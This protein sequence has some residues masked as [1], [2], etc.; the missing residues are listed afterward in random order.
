MSL[1]DLP[2]PDGVAQ[3]E[4]LRV[5]VGSELF[6]TG[7]KGEGD[8]DLMGVYIAPPS[9]VFGL[10]PTRDFKYRTQPEGVPSGPGDIDYTCFEFRKFMSL[11]AVGN[12][13]VLPIFFAS[14]NRCEVLTSL[15]EWMQ[16]SIPML[17]CQRAGYRYLGYSRGQRE[18]LERTLRGKARRQE[19]HDEYGYDTK[20]AMHTLMILHQG[21]ELMQDHTL[22]LPIKKPIRNTLLDVRYG[23]ITLVD[24]LR[25]MNSL[26]ADLINAIKVTTMRTNPDRNW[27]NDFLRE[28][29]ETFYEG[30]P[31]GWEE[32]A[33]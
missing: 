1:T 18:K 33:K 10:E 9:S 20:Y 15:G 12:P 5:R 32:G 13:H 27:I 30:I 14:E 29:H 4:I 19:L 11:A 31:H 28:V 24:A 25:M 2:L 3:G 8:I 23:K 22:T 26:E 21:I 7:R 6:G 17:L 16:R